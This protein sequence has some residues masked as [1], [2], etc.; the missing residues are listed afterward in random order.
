MLD[1]IVRYADDAAGLEKALRLAQGF[2]T[3]AV[4]LADAAE[5]A[6]FW[7]KMRSQFALGEDA[8]MEGSH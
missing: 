5:E 3:I 7:A 6:V 1:G 8:H 4:G 2:C